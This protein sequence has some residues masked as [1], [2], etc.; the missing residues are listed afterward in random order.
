MSHVFA[1]APVSAP[2]EPIQAS[3]SPISLFATVA[4]LMHGFA[5]APA[6]DFTLTRTVGACT[7]SVRMDAQP[8][9]HGSAVHFHIVLQLSAHELT[10]SFDQRLFCAGSDGVEVAAGAMGDGAAQALAPFVSLTLL[11]F[12]NS[13]HDIAGLD[14][15]LN[16]RLRPFDGVAGGWQGVHFVALYAAKLNGNPRFDE[17]VNGHLHYLR[18]Y[19]SPGAILLGLQAWADGLHGGAVQ[20]CRGIDSMLAQCPARLRAYIDGYTSASRPVHLAGSGAGVAFVDPNR[21]FRQIVAQA[22]LAAPA[23]AP[24]A[25]VCDLFMAEVRYA[26]TGTSVHPC[27]APLVHTML[28]NGEA[29]VLDVF[30]AGLEFG[31]HV[32]AAMKTI[33]LPFLLVSARADECRRRAQAASTDTRRRL[34]EDYAQFLEDSLMLQDAPMTV[35]AYIASYTLEASYR[36]AFK[37]NCASKAKDLNAAFRSQVREIVLQAPDAAPLH[38]VCDLFLAENQFQQHRPRLAHPQG[39]DEHALMLLAENMLARG[40]LRE[41][42]LFVM[43]VPHGTALRWPLNQLVLPGVM[44]HAYAGICEQ[45]SKDFAC[46]ER[47]YRYRNFAL[48]FAT[49]RHARPHGLTREHVYRAPGKLLSM[50]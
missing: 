33:T 29:A 27:V 13:C 25:L 2:I 41:L 12:L 43:C 36:I 8:R 24:I 47:V 38:L 14:R 42:D 22:V 49:L 50:Y 5:V 11:P 37:W 46:P 1:A 17:L 23:S 45:R 7:Q 6:P 16:E 9:R 18:T 30:E 21:P 20:S 19:D 28:V 31:E 34:L 4:G 32:V 15:L 40:S 39:E 3:A 26:A 35:E 48:F 44:A 10:F